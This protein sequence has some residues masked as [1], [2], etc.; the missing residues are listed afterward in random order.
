M[1]CGMS[2]GIAN[3]HV[4]SLLKR[5][6]RRKSSEQCRRARRPSIGCTIASSELSKSDAN[7]ILHRWSTH[8]IFWSIWNGY[9]CG[10]QCSVSISSSISSS[11]SFPSS[12]SCIFDT[13]RVS[14]LIARAWESESFWGYSFVRCN[15][16]KICSISL[17]PWRR[18][19]DSCLLRFETV[20][21]TWSFPCS[22]TSI[23]SLPSSGFERISWAR[24]SSWFLINSQ[25]HPDSFSLS[26]TRIRESS[27]SISP[28][29]S[30]SMYF[31]W[32]MTCS[33]FTSK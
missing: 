20:A 15:F 27:C 19:Y 9:I 22:K 7:G 2:A 33:S 21:A 8:M 30:C 13:S 11:S 23:S 6:L 5:S 3:W 18:L 10:L 31:M 17:F 4:A 25:S 24:D 16:K 1:G 29:I 32:R 26:S 14:S 12:A 28:P